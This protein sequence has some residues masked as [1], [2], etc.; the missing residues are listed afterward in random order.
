M[1]IFLGVHEFGGPLT[2]EQAEDNWKRYSAAATKMGA[3]PK[4][5]YFDIEHGRS[6]C[7]TEADSADVVNSAHDEEHL[8]TKELIE[9]Q[10]LT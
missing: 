6:W 8:P 10:K 4:G 5:V 9:V 1:T 2:Q 3:T 7:I